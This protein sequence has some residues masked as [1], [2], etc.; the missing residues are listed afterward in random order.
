MSEIDLNKVKF[1]SKNNAYINDW[2]K[3]VVTEDFQIA[4]EI[5]RYYNFSINKEAFP[6]ETHALSVEEVMNNSFYTKLGFHTP[7]YLEPEYCLKPIY[8]FIGGGGEIIR[9]YGYDWSV[10]GFVQQANNIFKTVDF[11]KSMRK[12]LLNSLDYHEQTL[13]SR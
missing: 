4:S 11:G 5:A 13:W 12:I 10:E 9:G 2:G 7:M 1:I 3:G 6:K 8:Y